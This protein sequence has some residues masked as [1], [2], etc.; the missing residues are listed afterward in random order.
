M[1]QVLRPTNNGVVPEVQ[2]SVSQQRLN[3]LSEQYVD[4]NNLRSRPTEWVAGGRP[5]YRRLPA[6]GERYQVDFFNF[7]NESNVLS[8]NQTLEGVE[9][10][11]YVYTPYGESINGPTST[12]VISSQGNK[13]LL[14]KAG[15]ILWEYG[16]TEVLPTLI[17]MEVLEVLSGKYT[18]AYQLIYDD[19]PVPKL[20]EVSD[21][22]LA[23]LPMD[24][25]S[26]TDSVVGWR[27]PPVNSFITTTAL[28]WSNEDS[29]FPSY[30]QPTEAYLQWKVDYGQSYTKVLLRCPPGTAYEG[31][32]TLSYVDLGVFSPVSTV[33]VSRDSVG[34]FF[35]F[36]VD[37]PQY[38]TEWNVTFSSLTVSV[39]S[40]FVS[41]SLTLL[42]SQAAPSPKAALV[43]Y[44]ANTLPRFVE[45]T[46]G[47]R[48][49]AVYCVLAE[50]DVDSNF[51]I[52]NVEDLRT[53]IHR[54]Y[55]PVADWLTKPFDQD[56]TNLY[57]QVS[58]Y[59]T[60]WM[61][62]ESCLTQEYVGLEQYQVQVEA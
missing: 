15:V 28:S 29:Y 34:Q 61:K 43:M 1:S 41:G 62:P 55:E 38:Q 31:T 40:V 10:V 4:L 5:V 52:E 35:E 50:V 30:T 45:N 25:T 60:L 47:E 42:E 27:F 8:S 22:S 51:T 48:V 20:Y 13:V 14:I 11:G 53:I 58:N 32:A 24:I 57:E 54:D 56:L 21:F 33:S 44:P 17:D 36:T 37:S 49:P 9:K 26:S 59:S 23:G 39:Q 46:Q 12:E 6:T 18:L 2:T 19:E 16:K 3:V 7:V